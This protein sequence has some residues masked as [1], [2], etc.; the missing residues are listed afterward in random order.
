[1]QLFD[2]F[3]VIGLRKFIIQDDEKKN[4]KR[5]SGLEK[6]NQRRKTI[7]FTI[8]ADGREHIGLLTNPAAHGTER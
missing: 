3:G 8:P 7:S 1:M 5:L 4:K 6:S 2:S